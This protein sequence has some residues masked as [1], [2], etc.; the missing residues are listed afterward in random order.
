M[1]D[2]NSPQH[3]HFLYIDGT[4]KIIYC[5]INTLSMIWHYVSSFFFEF[6]S[7]LLKVAFNIFCVNINV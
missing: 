3:H 2:G 5:L 4:I 7:I 6:Q 1:W